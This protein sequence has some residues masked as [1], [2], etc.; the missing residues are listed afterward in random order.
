M[1]LL[2][3]SLAHAESAFDRTFG[4][5]S[6]GAVRGGAYSSGGVGGRLRIQPF[7]HFGIDAYLE[8][9]V[10]D[11]PGGF[12]HD[13]PNGFNLYA[14]LPVGPVRFLPYFGACDVVSFGEP[15]QKGAPRADD[16]LIGLHAGVGAEWAFTHS[17]SLFVDGQADF[18][19]GHDRS[20]G[21][22]TG[23]VAEELV[24]FLTGQVNLGVQYHIPN[25]L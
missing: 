6:Y 18:Y 24:P 20:Q 19:G 17:L 12:R 1:L 8:A 21:G 22:W 11:W 15:T 4:I 10:V 23:D 16:V 2:L 14:A 9:A 3:A 13:Y 7:K 5:A 25:F